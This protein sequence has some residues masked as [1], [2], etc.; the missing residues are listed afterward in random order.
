MDK[1]E[2]IVYH[3]MIDDSNKQIKIDEIIFSKNIY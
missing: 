1:Q 2:Q 3:A